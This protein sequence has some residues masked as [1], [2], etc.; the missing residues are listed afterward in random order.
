MAKFLT[1]ESIAAGAWNRTHCTAG[2]G[3][4]AWQDILTNTDE[5]LHLT[6]DRMSRD[7]S[8]LTPKMRSAYSL[9]QVVP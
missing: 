3:M 6:I 7:W 1:H 8:N 9:K 4:Q 2:D 5:I